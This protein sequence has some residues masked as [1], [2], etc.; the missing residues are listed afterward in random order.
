MKNFISVNSSSFYSIQLV[1]LY[2]RIEMHDSY[3]EQTDSFNN[4]IINFIYVQEMVMD[5]VTINNNDIANTDP[6]GFFHFLL[7]DNGIIQASNISIMNSNIGVKPIIQF[8]VVGAA[9]MTLEDVFVQN[10]TLGIDTKIVKTQSL[11]SFNMKNSTFIEVKPQVSGDTTPKMIE[12]SSHILTDQLNN[13]IIDTYIEQSV[14]GF[15]ELSGI[16]SN[17]SLTSSF[18]V[19][20]FAYQNSYLDFSQDL[21]SFIGI[22]TTNNFWIELTDIYMNNITF[23]RTGRLLVLEHQTDMMLSISNGYFS[24]LEGASI[25][26][27]SS[28]L[29]IDMKTKVNMKNITATSLSGA[30]NSFISIDEGGELYLYDSNFT[31][32]ENT[33]RGAVLNAG[34]QN[35]YTEVHNTTFENNLSIYGGVANVQDGSA[36][37]FYDSN[38]T[39]NYA[40]QSG[41]IQAS[42][43]GYFEFYR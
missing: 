10:V 18:T 16:S 19:S 38:I 39:Y 24:D 13:T 36:I 37:K 7:F 32:I 23:S 26:I 5:N 28:N 33:E 34:Y 3:F 17:E 4:L 21:L 20:N 31:Q 35:S 40:I 6:V 42:N 29:N 12:L 41:V 9:S 25:S 22:E 2:G 43:D 11:K 1:S 14:I 27:K 15:M 30:S 8:E